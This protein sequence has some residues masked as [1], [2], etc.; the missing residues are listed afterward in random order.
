[1]Q[2]AV[3]RPNKKGQLFLLCVQDVAYG[4][5]YRAAV[6]CCRLA[7]D[8]AEERAVQQRCHTAF[9]TVRHFENTHCLNVQAM[10][11]FYLSVR[12]HLT[13]VTMDVCYSLG[14]QVGR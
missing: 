11:A 6:D 2:A 13:Q 9:S 14:L 10:G 12:P 4:G 3:N 1:M 8:L 5:A 7:G